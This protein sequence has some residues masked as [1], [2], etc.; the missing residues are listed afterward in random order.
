MICALIVTRKRAFSSLAYVRTRNALTA[1]KEGVPA[2][3]ALS[4]V[5]GPVED[6]SKVR[7]DHLMDAE[8]TFV[9]IVERKIERQAILDVLPICELPS[10][11][12]S[13][14]LWVPS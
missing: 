10:R 3:E 1:L 6:L 9:K 13:L 14:L 11:D 12:V 7:P 5:W 4:Y 2:Y 8:R